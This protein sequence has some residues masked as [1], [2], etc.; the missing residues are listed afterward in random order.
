MER[1]TKRRSIQEG[2]REEEG[3]AV[4]RRGETLIWRGLLN[5]GKGVA[6]V[7]T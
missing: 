1:Q 6:G 5:K 7:A 4:M 2:V 3:S